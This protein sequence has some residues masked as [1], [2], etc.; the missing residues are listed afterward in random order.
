MEKN[1][2]CSDL[3]DTMSLV[4]SRVSY[5]SALLES[6]IDSP[7]CCHFDSDEWLRLTVEL[8]CDELDFIRAQLNSA[9]LGGV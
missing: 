8:V 4:S 1:F 7:P 5:L 6:S 9:C 2:C 3:I